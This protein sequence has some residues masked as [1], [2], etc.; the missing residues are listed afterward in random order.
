IA[1]LM[2]ATQDRDRAA[3]EARLQEAYGV[4]QEQDA[5]LQVVLAQDKHV[6]RRSDRL[7]LSALE[8]MLEDVALE[9]QE[10]A[11]KAEHM[12][13]E[14]EQFSVQAERLDKDRLEFEVRK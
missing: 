7:E 4:M 1:R 10:L 5:M 2:D 6:T 13:S 14:R 3:M 9:R 12:A 11:I 8:D